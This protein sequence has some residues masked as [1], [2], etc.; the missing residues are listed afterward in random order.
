MTKIFLISS[1]ALLAAS[2]ARAEP[3]AQTLQRESGLVAGTK[4]ELAPNQQDDECLEGELIINDVNPTAAA[5]MI[6]SNML[7]DGVGPGANIPDSLDEAECK[8]QRPDKCYTKRSSE[9]VRMGRVA[10]AKV[11]KR[12]HVFYRWS[13]VIEVN[14]RGLTYTEVIGNTTRVCRLVRR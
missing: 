6:G 1:V 13:Y 11:L 9:P 5:I 12:P 8:G 2:S 4:Y 7:V 14:D 10:A 3:Y